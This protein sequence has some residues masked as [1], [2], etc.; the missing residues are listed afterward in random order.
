MAIET[1]YTVTYN[2]QAPWG[3]GVSGAVPFVSVDIE[4]VWLAGQIGMIRTVSLNGTIPSGGTAQITAIKNCFSTNFKPFSAPN[5]T[6]TGAMVQEINF[7]SQNYIGKVDYAVT[8]KDF[9]GFPLTVSDPVDE[10]AFQD[11]PDGSVIINHKV[12]AQGVDI[13]GDAAAAFNNAKNFVLGRTGLSTINSLTTSFISSGNQSH[14]YVVSQQE[15]IN[16]AGA[17]YGVSEVFRYDPLRDI[18]SNTCRRFSVELN[19]GIADDYVQVSVNGTYQVGKD[20]FDSGLFA[21]TSQTELFNLASVIYSNLNPAP[22]SLNVDADSAFS[23][24]ALWTR[25]LNVRAVFDNSPGGSFFDY[26]Y[27][28]SKDYR[29]GITQVNIRGQIVG[30]GR[31][32][33]RKFNSALSFFNTTVGGWNGA[34]NF[35]Y[36][37][38]QSGV[39]AL[40]YTTY[41]FNPQPKAFSVNFNSGQ[42]SI[43][44]SATFDDT[45]FAS[46]YSEFGWN[47][48]GDCGLNVFRPH[49]S[50]NQNGSYIIQD[51][52]II[53]RSSISL[54]GNFA[55]LS[56]GGSHSVHSGIK[57][58]LTNIEGTDRAFLESDTDIFASGET[59][60]TGFSVN[61]T[62]DGC[63]G[64]TLPGDG[65]IYA[66]TRI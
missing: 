41:S 45:P 12:S 39:I 61:Y 10:I 24:S 62:K 64:V 14:T 2:G 11:Q 40:G 16:R 7:G 43:T 26:D 13:S 9:S 60:K 29:D 46:G 3:T 18:V 57:D 33:R 15:N 17:S 30:S 22:V 51:L 53:N 8:L 54:N 48:G 19:S 28:I 58:V 23:S 37:A 44:F 55:F 21:Q 20:V 25:N 42:G 34:A 65:K 36:A 49:P 32:V 5:I 31:H 50:A 4:E 63:G 38:A 59:I 56:S 47:V 52:G 6:M 66:G 35:A 1:G 27:E